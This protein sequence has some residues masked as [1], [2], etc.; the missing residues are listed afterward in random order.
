[1]SSW[2]TDER[3]ALRASARRF[4]EAE[5]VPNLAAWEEGGALPRELHRAAAAAHLL[6]VGFPEWAG[7][8]GGS[9]VDALVIAEEI[10]QSGGSSGLVAGLFTHGIGL[11]HLVEAGDPALIDKVARPVLAGE[12]IVSLAITEPDAGSDVAHLRTR[13]VRDGGEF[14]VSGG[15][16]YITSATRADFFTVAVRTGGEGAGGISLL[17]LEREMR[18]VHVSAPLKKM[19]WLCSDTAELRFDEVRVPVGNLIGEENGG[20]YSIMRQFAAERLSLAV[21]AYATA[22]RCLDLTLSWIRQ[23]E[24]FG[25]PLASRQVIQHR[26]AEM[27]RQTDVARTYT[28]AVVDDWQAGENVFARVA[29][30]KNTAVAACDYV[31]DNAV[32]LHGGLGYM[33]ES[34]VE[35]HYR[36]SRILGIGGGTNEIMTEIVARLLIT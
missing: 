1:M 35:R 10:I 33:R 26:V 20:F 13:A 22:Q 5:V 14:V 32:Q 21:Q 8:S 15:K 34:E 11:P 31:V 27:A 7:G 28:R 16:L 23:R 30:A 29:M 19:G 3:N 24:T 6:G 9:P 18:G 12:K 2:D 36:D 17:V 25:R 4:T